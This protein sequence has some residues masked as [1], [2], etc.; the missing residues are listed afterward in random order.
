RV[1]L[2][3]WDEVMLAPQERDFIFIREPYAEAFWE[4]Y[5]PCEIDWTAL[6]YYRWERVVQDTIECA[7]NV[8]FKDDLG[9][10]SRAG[11]VQMFQEMFAEGAGNVAAAYAA[12]FQLGT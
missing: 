3:D 4:G 7:R 9:E 5:G 1:F 2:I 12:E 8:Y 10:E 11:V 6:T